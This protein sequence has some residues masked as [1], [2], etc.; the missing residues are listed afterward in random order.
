MM[1]KRLCSLCAV[2]LA[3][4]V[5]CSCQSSPEPNGLEAS[6]DPERAYVFTKAASSGLREIPV[7]N[8]T[9]YEELI[10]KEVDIHEFAQ[11]YTSHYDIYGSG[12]IDEIDAAFGVECLRETDA[13]ALYSVHKVKQGG[14]LYIFYQNYT[15]HQPVTDTPIRRWFYVRDRLSS[16]DFKQYKLYKSTMDDMMKTDISLQ[17]FKNLFFS[18]I[19]AE[20]GAWRN[21]FAD[22]TDEEIEQRKQELKESGEWK[23]Y[24]K[25]WD[26]AL[27]MD[28]LFE[29]WLYLEDGIYTLGFGHRDGEL[30]YLVNELETDF[31]LKDPLAGG[32]YPY[33][34]HILDMDWV[35]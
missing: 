5:F 6:Y 3:A 30:I 35:K 32:S 14:L 17:I 9:P 24:K 13:G 31:D 22:M 12:R 34:A 25:Y 1:K 16:E 2:L 18:H 19:A 15:P 4:T 11:D 26:T 8:T 29:V 10:T 21:D 20:P 28:Y 23:Q 27:S 7:D 33:D